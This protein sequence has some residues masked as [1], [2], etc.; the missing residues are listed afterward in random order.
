[1]NNTALYNVTVQD[2]DE[3]ICEETIEALSAAQATATIKEEL[4]NKRTDVEDLLVS[5]SKCAVH[6]Y[7]VRATVLLNVAAQTPEQAQEP[8]RAMDVLED[9][10]QRGSDHVQFE[11]QEKMR[12]IDD[13]E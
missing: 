4:N 5:A 7:T 2:S 1:M 6:E 8:E 13:P 10:I 3:T 9:R 11:A 12:T